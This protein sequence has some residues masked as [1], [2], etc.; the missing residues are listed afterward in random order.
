MLQE[1]SIARAAAVPAVSLFLF[2]AI[3]LL[4]MDRTPVEAVPAPKVT[5]GTTVAAISSHAL[6]DDDE[7]IADYSFIYPETYQ[8]HAPAAAAAYRPRVVNI[9]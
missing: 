1:S 4:A 5:S 9:P 8:E 6:P 7:D 3:V 2:G